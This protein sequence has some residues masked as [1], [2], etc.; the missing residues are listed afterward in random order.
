MDRVGH[1]AEVFFAGF[2]F[3]G[4]R[5]VMFIFTPWILSHFIS[6]FFKRFVQSRQILDLC[7]YV[8]FIGFSCLI[9]FYVSSHINF[10][11]C[12]ISYLTEECHVRMELLAWKYTVIWEVVLVVFGS[13]A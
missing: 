9:F 11:S 4:T 2:V 3:Y 8:V 13:C 1:I 12:G 7:Q 10:M 5:V 6:L